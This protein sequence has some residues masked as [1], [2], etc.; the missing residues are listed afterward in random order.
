ML[1]SRKGEQY[2]FYVQVIK[3]IQQL[4]VSTPFWNTEKKRLCQIHHYPLK[5]SQHLRCFGLFAPDEK[6]FS[7]SVKPQIIRICD[8]RRLHKKC[9][10]FGRDLSEVLLKRQHN[11]G[12]AEIF[13]RERAVFWACRIFISQATRIGLMG[14]TPKNR[15]SQ[16]KNLFYLKE[17]SMYYSER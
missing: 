15:V 1:L 4:V 12:K 13:G 9:W 8:G 5:M 14:P 16:S 3:I 17:G 10:E 11:F 2:T 6:I 7:R